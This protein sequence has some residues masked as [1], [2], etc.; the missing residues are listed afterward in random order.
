MKN[1]INLRNDVALL[2]PEVS[3]KIAQF[4][5]QVKEIKEQEDELKKA[6][7]EEM[8]TKGII[9]VETEDLMISYVAGTD[10]ERFNTKAFRKDNPD[11][12][13]EYISMIPVKASIRVKVKERRES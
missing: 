1:L 3:A 11:L 4:E 7:I 8:E 12:Y 5:R 2:D 9:K 6:I 13:D 10:R